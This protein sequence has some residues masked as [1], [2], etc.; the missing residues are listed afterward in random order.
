MRMVQSSRGVAGIRL[1]R[2]NKTPAV[3]LGANPEERC[4]RKNRH[5]FEAG[6]RPLIAEANVQRV[7]E[8]ICRRS[9]QNSELIGE[10]RHQPTRGI[11][12]KLIQVHGDNAPC[13]L[14][15]RLH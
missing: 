11:G 13:P 1:R 5:D 12:G 4:K 14:N 9:Q 8:R 10:S 3:S 6:D 2:T 15:S 7:L